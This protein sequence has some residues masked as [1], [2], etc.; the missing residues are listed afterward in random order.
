M[1]VYGPGFVLN[2]YTNSTAIR[3]AQLGGRV[4]F[5]RRSGPTWSALGAVQMWL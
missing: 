2:S 4:K 5:P 3:Q 1:S